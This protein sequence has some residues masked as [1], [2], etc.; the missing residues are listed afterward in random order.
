MEGDAR[1]GGRLARAAPRQIP[2]GGGPQAGE[3]LERPD[4]A[5]RP[6][7]ERRAK[8]H[9]QS[10]VAEKPELTHLLDRVQSRELDPLSAVREILERVYG[11]DEEDGKP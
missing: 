11:I 1:Q 8:A 10:T 9:L 5:H 2:G 7:W 4:P 3:G 6:A